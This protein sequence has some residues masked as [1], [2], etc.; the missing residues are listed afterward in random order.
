MPN[1]ALFSNAGFP[2][3][4]YAD[5]RKTTVVLPESPDAKEI[6]LY[7]YLMSHFGAQTG[8]PALRVTVA[9]P[10]AAISQGRDYLVLGTAGN[11]PAFQSLDTIMPVALSASGLQVKP[12]IGYQ[13]IIGRV[14]N[15]A[16]NKWNSLLG[17]PP[18]PDLSTVAGVPDA[19]VQEAMSP[20]SPD[21]S[22]VMV[23][24]RQDSSVDPFAAV[25]LD[26]SQTRDM[27]GP[28][29]LLIGSGPGSR[30][31]SYPAAGA[32]YH[33]GD[34]SDYVRLRI[35][36]GESYLLLLLAVTPLTL[37]VALWTYGWMAR[38]AHQ[39]LKLGL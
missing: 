30:L 32:R 10:N 7:L 13:A 5:L 11:Q 31:Q 21:R 24:L 18:I 25:F 12:A 4:Q 14:Q 22:I 16:L 9:G 35:W 3:T 23:A 19:L 34:A 17:K 2:F 26:H 6:A 27:N 8:Y 28:V 33:I 15:L 20:V 1:L 29:S 36:F 37:L 39:R 38:R